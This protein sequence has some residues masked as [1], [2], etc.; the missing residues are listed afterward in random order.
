MNEKKMQDM[1]LEEG[2]TRACWIDVDRLVFDHDLRHYCV[3][4][5]CGNYE[6]N[7]ACPP[8]C[9]S[10][11]DMEKRVRSYKRAL[12]L[13]TVQPVDSVMD[14]EQTKTARQFH[15][16]IT[17]E[18]VTAYENM[19]IQ[20]LSVMAGPCSYCSK[21]ARIEG[22]PCRFPEKAASC[23]SAYCIDAGAMAEECGMPYWCGNDEVPFF[24][25]FLTKQRDYIDGN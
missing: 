4:N 21:C 9:G 25:I 11:E 24:S 2:F 17:R 1:A 15:N 12:V 16:M 23:L 10:P 14:T 5:T 20:G 18:L 6:R 22:Q 19:G 7:Y 13:Q 8:D 3:E